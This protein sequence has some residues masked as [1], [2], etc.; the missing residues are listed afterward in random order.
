MLP[1]QSIPKIL[2]G[3]GKESLSGNGTNSVLSPAKEKELKE[4]M[5][6]LEEQ[7]FLVENMIE[8][9]RR[10]RRIEEVA[11][12]RESSDELTAEIE[13]IKE[14]LKDAFIE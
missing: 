3:K 1:L 9:A 5:M 11:A 13:K 10:G 2:G 7:K 12:L 14:E 4:R 6:V 8:K